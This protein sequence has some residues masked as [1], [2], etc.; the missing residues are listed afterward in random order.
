MNEE[1]KSYVNTPTCLLDFYTH[2]SIQHE[3]EGCDVA[4]FNVMLQVREEGGGDRFAETIF[5]LAISG[6][7]CI[8]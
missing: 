8:F 4:L 2:E 5:K 6:S 1:G 3:G 7:L